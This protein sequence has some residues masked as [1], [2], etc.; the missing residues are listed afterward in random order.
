[1][2]RDKGTIVVHGKPQRE[3]LLEELNAICEKA[4]VSTK[5]AG[6]GCIVDAFDIDSPLNGILSALNSAPN[7]SWLVVAVDMPYVDR[8]AFQFLINLR[9]PA[10]LATCFYN[11][12]TSLPEPLLA[13][14]EPSAFVPLKRFA[15]EGHI[16]PRDFL[17][18]NDIRVVDPPDSKVFYNMNRPEDVV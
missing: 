14:W 4:F 16:S 8:N 9:D 17:S 18:L 13:I 2:G 10:K 7:K 1:M 15:D 6:V 12:Q 11:T 3:Y 5:K